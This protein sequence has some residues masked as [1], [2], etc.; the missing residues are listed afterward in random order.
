[1]KPTKP[2]FLKTYGKHKRRVS[3]WIGADNRRKAFDTET[4]SS[5]DTDPSF[6]LPRHTRLL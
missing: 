1:M 3:A 4:D 6:V 2:L 5:I